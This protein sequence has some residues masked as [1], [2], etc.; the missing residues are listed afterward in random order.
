MGIGS[1]AEVESNQ[2]NIDEHSLLQGV[3]LIL[4]K[5]DSNFI[6]LI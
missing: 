5:H 4:K 6:M 1:P 3:M 2:Q